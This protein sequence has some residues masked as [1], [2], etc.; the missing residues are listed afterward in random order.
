MIEAGIGNLMIW[1]HTTER[2]NM[3]QRRSGR[4][5]KILGALVMHLTILDVSIE[6]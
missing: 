5:T 4:A 3:D 1:V 2:S 6:L